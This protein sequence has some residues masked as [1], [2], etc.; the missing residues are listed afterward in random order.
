M[1]G[2]SNSCTDISITFCQN[3]GTDTTHTKLKYFFKISPGRNLA[4]D[5][6]EFFVFKKHCT[7]MCRFHDRTNNILWPTQSKHCEVSFLL[8]V[9]CFLAGPARDNLSLPPLPA[10]L[11]IQIQDYVADLPEPA[12]A[13]QK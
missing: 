1:P 2:N 6:G 11:M 8:A 5:A 4:R 10:S 12:K 3:S 9:S 7:L 13:A